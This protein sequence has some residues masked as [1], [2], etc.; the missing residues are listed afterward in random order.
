MPWLLPSVIATLTGTSVLVFIYLYLFVKDRKDYLGIWSVS[1]SLYFIRYV[2]TLWIIIDRETPIL[3]IANQ[4]ASFLSG[5]FLLWGT[6]RFIGIRFPRIFIYGIC[7]GIFWVIISVSVKLSFLMMT[8]PTFAFLAIVYIWTGFT[9]IRSNITDGMEKNITGWTFIIWGLHKA[10][11][12]FVRPITWMAPWGYLFG[13]LLEFMIAMGILLVYYQKIREDLRAERYYLK[14]AQEI[15]QIGTWDLDLINNILLWTDENC[16]IFEVPEGSVAD[17]EIFIDKVHPDDREYVER[18]W[19]KAFNGKPY[20]IEH[21]L[22]IDGKVKWV[23][24]KGDVEFNKEGF[25][26]KAIGVTQD[27]TERKKFEETLKTEHDFVNNLMYT[28][29]AGITRVNADGELVYANRRAEEIL[30]ISLSES[31]KRTYDDPKWIITDLEGNPFPGEKLPF[32][33]VRKTL[34]PVFDVQHAIKWPDGKKVILSIN[35][36]PLFKAD[37]EFGGMVASIEDITGRY[38]AEQKY[39]MLF[40]KMIDGFA[41]HEIICNE[42]GVPVDYRFLDVNPAF[43][44][45]TGLKS[46]DITGRTVLEIMPN[47]ESHWIENYGQVAL[48]GRP[49]EF[50]EYSKEVD[51]YFYVTAFRPAPLQFACIFIDVTDRKIAA[52]EKLRLE[53]QLQQAQ[54]MEGIGTLAGG[55]AHDFNNILSPIMLHC[56]MVMDDLSEDNPIRHDIEQIFKASTRAR[57]LVKQILTFARKRPEE[58]IVLKSSPIIQ[59]AVKF[60]RS[61][62]PTTIDIKLDIKAGHDV[63]LADPTQINQIVM[64]L[65]TNAAHVM[66]EKGGLLEVI[67]DNEEGSTEK[68]RMNPNLKNREYLKLS[69]VDNGTGIPPDDIKRIFEPYFTTKEIGEGTGLGLATVHG[70]VKNYGGD[71]IVESE[72]GKGTAFHVYIPLID[73]MVTEHVVSEE[74]LPTGTERILFVDDEET[75]VKLIERMLKRLGYEVTAN[76]N[77]VEAF[78]LCRENPD[79][80]DLVITDMTMPKLTGKDLAIKVKELRPDLPVI[81]CTGFSDKI[82][83]NKARE[84]GI[85]AFIMKPVQRHE[86]AYTIR[87]VLDKNSSIV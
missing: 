5:V 62:I 21:R 74:E 81:L 80:Y 60:L 3:L 64:N 59:E 13:T 68:V 18:E 69:V 42:E 31:T 11:Y 87:N 20:D 37:G 32:D 30:S 29:P 40:L 50:E 51:R 33:I 54:K 35:A 61:T 43:E 82:D 16:R 15:G 66:N 58:K 48:T 4:L 53:S 1:W 36:S 28:S 84:L 6:Y 39:Q 79:A 63:I 24:E 2:F 45:M 14:K 47:T 23:R 46:E 49:M 41:L 75:I 52:E 70:I 86:I 12:P 7:V 67:L 73:E 83:K 22:L 10:D 78:Q 17:Y 65:C 38:I 56:E 85:A 25:G 26:I 8:L 19:K 57:D 9:F 34:E 71:I 77:S 72:V 55:I 44:R 27:I 76:T